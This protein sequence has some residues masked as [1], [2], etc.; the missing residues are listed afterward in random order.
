MRVL[1][2]ILAVLGGVALFVGGTLFVLVGI[3]EQSD[4]DG[5]YVVGFVPGADCDDAHELYLRVEDGSV[6][7]CLPA[8]S[9]ARL[10]RV[11][12]PGFTDEQDEQLAAL[13][14]RLAPDG[15]PAAEQRELQLGVDAL[16]AAVP[17][18]ARP[19]GDRAVWGAGRAWLGAGMV[20]A[21]IIGVGLGVRLASEPHR[22]PGRT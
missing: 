11:T 2:M 9:S 4:A 3:A 21:G 22:S 1:L 14:T 12:L 5:T 6:L 13:L 18:E 20:V 19:Y 16:A 7:R 17:P 10:G 8:G 15:L